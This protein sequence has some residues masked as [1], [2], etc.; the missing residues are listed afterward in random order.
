MNSPDPAARRRVLVVD[1][2]PHIRRVLR[3]Y[4]EADGFAVDE[5]GT[6]AQA[7]ELVGAADLVLLDIGLPDG[8]GLDL[9]RD[10][11]AVSPVYVI[12]VTARAEEVDRLIGLEAGADD[13]VVKPFSPREV[14]A[15]VRAVLRRAR[16]TG[17][18]VVATP[19]LTVGALTVDVG[20]REVAVDGSAVPLTP[21][22]FDLLATMT[23]APG[24]VFS[25]RQLLDAVWQD[26]YFGD[27]RVVDVHVRGLRRALGD[28]PAAPRFVATVRGAG[29]KVL[30]PAGHGGAR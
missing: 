25:R 30:R 23:A 11:R 21:I 9:L 19:P 10:L 18:V 15:R 27:E 1:D 17:P 6:A 12:L 28:D 22:E 7:R 16:E 24:Q 26:G 20:A 3:G 29:Y 13:Y 2:E 14:T 4:L 5:A 8:N